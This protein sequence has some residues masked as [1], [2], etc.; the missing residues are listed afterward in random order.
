[1]PAIVKAVPFSQLWSSVFKTAAKLS[2][3][4]EGT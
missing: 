2:V 1:V 3:L 4:K